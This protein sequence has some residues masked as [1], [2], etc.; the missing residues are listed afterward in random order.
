MNKQTA[1]HKAL[2]EIIKTHRATA[3]ANRAAATINTVADYWQGQKSILW[4]VAKE[5]AKQTGVDE[6]AFLKSCGID[7]S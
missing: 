5:Y 3:E 4:T 6:V 1:A 2:A 7:A